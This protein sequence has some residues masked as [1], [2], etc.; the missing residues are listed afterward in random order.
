VATGQILA[1]ARYRLALL[2]ASQSWLGPV[3]LL[4]VA[5][6]GVT[7]GNPHADTVFNYAA[8][9]LLPCVIWLTR[10]ALIAE[11][12]RVYSCTAT[13]VGT[14]RAHLG[15]VLAAA[16]A[17]LLV[18]M[19]TFVA[20]SSLVLVS[21]ATDAHGQD[22][23]LVQGI[24]VFLGGLITELTA[25]AVGIA[26]AVLTN[27]PVLRRPAIGLFW[28][29]IALVFAYVSPFSPAHLAFTSYEAGQK[30]G[31]AAGPWM[32]LLL[33]LMLLGACSAGAVLVAQRRGLD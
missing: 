7:A 1:L 8:A 16:A 23:G 5:L 18:C 25:T 30:T 32:A 9:V 10:A 14:G 20:I 21:G 13:A 3:A 27:G 4:G 22:L 24:P 31:D 19:T 6:A 2:I 17:A 33:G 26:I 29:A 11:P 12:A 15:V 28:A